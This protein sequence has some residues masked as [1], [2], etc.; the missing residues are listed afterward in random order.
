MTVIIVQAR[1]TGTTGSDYRFLGPPPQRWWDGHTAATYMRWEEFAVLV[2]SDGERWQAAVFGIA[3]KHRDV[4]TRQTQIMLAISGDAH[5]PDAE[6]LRGL[7]QSVLAG[8]D[9]AALVSDLLGEEFP[10]QEIV[11]LRDWA[12]ALPDGEIPPTAEAARAESEIR[13]RRAL[14]K[15]PACSVPPW[16]E[17]PDIGISCHVLRDGAEEFLAVVGRLCA[18]RAGRAVLTA[19]LQDKASADIV[20]DELMKQPGTSIV[21]VTVGGDAFDRAFWEIPVEPEPVAADPK[22]GPGGPG[23]SDSSRGTGDSGVGRPPNSAPG[24]RFTPAPRG[25]DWLTLWEPRRDFELVAVGASGGQLVLTYTKSSRQHTV[26]VTLRHDRL[27]AI[28]EIGI[29]GGSGPIRVEVG[30]TRQGSRLKCAGD[31]TGHGSR[32]ARVEVVVDC[33]FHWAGYYD[34]GGGLPTLV[35]EGTEFVTGIVRN[36]LSPPSTPPDRDG[37]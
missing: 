20:L 17:D 2:E 28:L 6:L 25:G 33:D 21:L 24:G 19:T 5:D 10:Q 3:A 7:L 4:L 9:G 37:R 16:M 15:L 35:S 34:T 29:D 18:G 22:G 23:S 31:V 27:A 32:I 13:A 8:E 36:V 14:A 26:R 12:A 30:V 11:K 1:G